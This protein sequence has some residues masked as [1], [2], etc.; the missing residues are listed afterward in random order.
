MYLYV[1]IYIYIYVYIYIYIYLYIYITEYICFVRLS[2][3]A[4]AAT[5]AATGVGGIIT[6]GLTRY[7]PI[8]LR[9][10][11]HGVGGNITAG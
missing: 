3:R 11:S 1:Y 4:M 5:A 2:R 7:N 8:C 6:A 10:H 9:L